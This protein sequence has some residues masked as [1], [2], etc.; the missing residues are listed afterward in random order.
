LTR[1]GLLSNREILVW[2][3]DIT[4][5][6]K[7]PRVAK[8][9]FMCFQSLVDEVEDPDVRSLLQEV[10]RNIK[11][12]KTS[13]VCETVTA[14][15]PALLDQLHFR[16]VAARVVIVSPA[17]GGASAEVDLPALAAMVGVHTS[18]DIYCGGSEL[19][20]SDQPAP[21]GYRAAFSP[22][23]VQWLRD[24]AQQV[25]IWAIPESEADD[26]GHPKER[27]L[28]A[29]L[30]AAVDA[31][32]TAVVL[33]GS[34]NFTN[35]GLDGTNRELMARVEVSEAALN[36]QL[37]ELGARRCA[38]D[39]QPSLRQCAPADV[40]PDSTV[41]LLARFVPDPNEFSSAKRWRGDLFL[42]DFDGI[43]QL[44]YLGQPLKRAATQRL[45][46]RED[47]WNLVA[48]TASGNEVVSIAVDAGENFWLRIEPPDDHPSADD[49]LAALLFDLGARPTAVPVNES[50][51]APF[52]GAKSGSPGDDDVYR[53][54]L[55]RRLVVLAR[56]RHQLRDYL[57]WDDV[58]T[59][60]DKYLSGQAESQVGS[61]LLRTYIGDA[62]P[63]TTDPLLISLPHALR[64]FDSIQ[65]EA[66]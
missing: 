58:A 10:R 44:H 43:E 46:L 36:Q 42:S 16:G 54:P 57:Q 8:N 23:A 21:A 6:T 12:T 25:R 28:H 29:K 47:V 31:R 27:P 11:A 5:Q 13:D 2:D 3:G 35:P 22:A 64:D 65:A 38:D 33:V 7:S 59:M 32:G 17:F 37:D 18:V 19:P 34:A 24:R 63:G 15:S 62:E 39:V 53:I 41:S 40:V 61:A 56:R 60:L 30:F 4:Q 49:E 48:T 51:S 26:S 20:P 14:K 45:D 1:G 55:D 50:D 52:D 9:L 66:P